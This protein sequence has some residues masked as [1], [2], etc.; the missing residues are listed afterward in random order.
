MV[1]VSKGTKNN[2][3]RFGGVSGSRPD[4]KEA[5]QEAT[6]ERE[7]YWAGL[8]PVQQLAELDK[9]GVTAKKQRARIQ[10]A[11]DAKTQAVQTA[12]AAEAATKSS[13]EGDTTRG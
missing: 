9:R 12:Q 10:R 5:R 8:T 1:A 3:R 11:I 13:E 4:K 7:A 2:E 6:V